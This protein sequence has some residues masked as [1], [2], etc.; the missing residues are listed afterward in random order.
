MYIHYKYINNIQLLRIY[1]TYTY[2]QFTCTAV[3]TDGFR[4]KVDE[5]YMPCLHQC[6]PHKLRQKRRQCR[7]YL[8]FSYI[9]CSLTP[10]S[11]FKEITATTL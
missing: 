1:N 9:Y 6:Y 11:N 8:V 4:L 2:I 3:Y 5:G 10:R 7:I